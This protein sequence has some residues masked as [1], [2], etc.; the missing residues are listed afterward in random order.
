MVTTSPAPSMTMP[1]PS[2]SSP[3]TPH[4]A[5]VVR[6]ERLDR[7][8]RAEQRHEIRLRG[9]GPRQ[10]SGERAC[11]H[12]RRDP[13]CD[14]PAAGCRMYHD[15]PPRFEPGPVLV[16]NQTEQARSRFRCPRRTIALSCRFT[17]EYPIKADHAGASPRMQDR[18]R[19]V[20][21]RSMPLPLLNASCRERVVRGRWAAAT[22][23]LPPAGD[24]RVVF[25]P[26][27]RFKIKTLN[28]GQ[29]P[30]RASSAA[31]AGRVF[32]SRNSRK[33]PP[34]VET[35]EISP[36]TPERIDGREGVAATRNRERRRAGDCPGDLAGTGRELLD[37]ED[38]HRPVPHHGA[39][40]FE[41][42]CVRAGGVGADVEDDL[43]V[44]D[45]AH[46]L[47]GRVRGLR[48]RARHHHVARDGDVAAA[49]AHRVPDADGL[50]DE[51]G[52]VERGA[53]L[54]AGGGDEG[55]GDAP[56]RRSADPPAPRALPAPRAWSIPWSRRRSRQ[57]GAPDARGP[58]RALRAPAARSGPAQATGAKRATPWVEAWARCAA[59]KASIT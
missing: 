33:A 30:A 40:R 24:G 57:A 43:A 22:G 7:D 51:L 41:H 35:Y 58:C 59:P 10:C 37:L 19:S 28:A 52:L 36:L 45:L 6:D 15:H 4:R 50:R 17:V 56:A 34:P 8:H 16:R 48:E 54:V 14:R 5:G 3:S 29:P 31:T 9:G 44:P 47:D 13:A 38:P 46:R 49:P 20:H 1:V 26:D 27:P 53:H 39:G 23:I 12:E 32:P 25:H 42:F 11:E 21:G 18:R 55:V 2:R